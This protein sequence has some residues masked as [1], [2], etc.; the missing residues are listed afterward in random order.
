MALSSQLS[1]VKTDWV[2]M[3]VSGNG[4]KGFSTRPMEVFVCPICS[5]AWACDYVC[6]IW[7]DHPTAI[8]TYAYLG[9]ERRARSSGI[10]RE[11]GPVHTRRAAGVP[12][13]APRGNL[14]RGWRSE[15]RLPHMLARRKSRCCLSHDC[16]LVPRP[17][18]PVASAILDRYAPE[19]PLT[20]VSDQR[21][22]AIATPI[23][24][25]MHRLASP[26]FASRRTISC[27]KVTRIRQPEA[28]I[29]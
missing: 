21:S 6:T 23:P 28:P 8:R 7:L 27:S 16:G 25:P 15:R 20:T 3:R 4:R 19:P 26:F 9:E 29:G 24:P 2:T 14:S 1:K 22:M 10:C 13:G 11:C 5:D 17:M 12:L 18:A